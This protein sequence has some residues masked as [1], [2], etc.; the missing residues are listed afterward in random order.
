MKTRVPAWLRHLLERPA[1]VLGGGVSGCAAA[2]LIAHLG[3]SAE[4]YDLASADASRRVFGADEAG[5]HGLVIVSP[6]FAPDHPWVAAARTAGCEVLGE[7]DLGALA[8]PGVILAVTGTNG[9]TTLTSFLA[10]ALS[11]AGRDARAVGNIGEAF[12]DAWRR[13]ADRSSIA[14]CEVSSFQAETLRHFEAEAALWSNFAEDHL[15]RHGTLEAYF[16]AKHHLV[17][18]TRGRR[19]FFGPDVLVQARALGLDLPVSGC[20]PF[21]AEALDPGVEATSFALR[22]QRENYLLARALWRALGLPVG[23]LVEA[24]AT[25]TPGPHRMARVAEL[26]GVAFWNDSKATNF[27]AAEAALA[28]FTRPV[29]WIGGGRSKGGDLAAFAARLAGRVRRAF[30]I[31]ETAPALAGHL[32]AAGVPH[33]RCATLEAAVA[34]AFAVAVAGDHVLLSPGF[35]SFDMFTGYDDRGRRFEALVHELRA[36][37]GGRPDPSSTPTPNRPAA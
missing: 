33:T 10:H 7:L 31:G 22:P 5:G 9:K 2:G 12:C 14:V 30:L 28:N 29:L 11:L 32:D 3:G 37:N 4:V 8:W 16:R 24:A 27:H 26:R 19:V 13:P 21:E 18:R 23:R 25:F 17:T 34:E 35:A 20:V 15:E 1:A 36:A 6:G